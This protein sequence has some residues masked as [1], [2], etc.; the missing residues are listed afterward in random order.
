[1]TDVA[2]RKIFS[3]ILM[4][5]FVFS[6]CVVICNANL[7]LLND[8]FAIARFLM[9]DSVAWLLVIQF[10][11]SRQ[12]TDFKPGKEQWVTVSSGDLY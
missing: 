4:I 7:H 10:Y 2:T 3:L 1:M 8:N 12:I 9:V 11:F 6:I 5:V